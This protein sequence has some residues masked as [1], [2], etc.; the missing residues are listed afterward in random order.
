MIELEELVLD[1]SR[2]FLGSGLEAV[3]LLAL[4]ISS[5]HAEKRIATIALPCSLVA[6]M[7]KRG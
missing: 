1:R 6:I 2:K 7:Q 3:I 5:Y 4:F